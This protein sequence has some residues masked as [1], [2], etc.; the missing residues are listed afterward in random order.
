MLKY[1]TIFIIV[2][3][4]PSSWI[5]VKTKKYSL[6]G[7]VKRC[8]RWKGEEPALMECQHALWSW[9]QVT[10]MALW[11]HRFMRKEARGTEMNIIL[12]FSVR[13][14][15]IKETRKQWVV[16]PGI[17]QL[18]T[19]Q[20]PLEV[21]FSKIKMLKVSSLLNETEVFV[22]KLRWQVEPQSHQ[23]TLWRIT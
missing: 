21:V 22:Y 18:R 11:W 3:N 14:I 23:N 17:A 8:L 9:K 12:P 4:Y 6:L 10:V 19:N 16:S 1:N 2:V 20:E 7:H 5:V 13:G 15:S